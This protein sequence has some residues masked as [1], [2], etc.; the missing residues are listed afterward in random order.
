MGKMKFFMD[1]HDSRTGTFPEGI[2]Q[3]ELDEFYK[4]YA[5]A[6]EEEG[7]IS[8]K[9]HVG[10]SEG[11]AFCFNMAESEEAVFRVHE[12]VG[13]PYDSIVEIDSIYPLKESN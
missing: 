12:K 1:T 8:V 9:T 5:K 4:A 2:K 11:K 6:C 10:N 3:N 13:L 7:V